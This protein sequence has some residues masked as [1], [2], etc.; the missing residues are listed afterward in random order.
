MTRTCSI[1]SARWQIK[2]TKRFVK[3]FLSMTD[4]HTNTIS[5]NFKQLVWSLVVLQK[6]YTLSLLVS[7]VLYND[8]IEVGSQIVNSTEGE[9]IIELDDFMQRALPSARVASQKFTKYFVALV[10]FKH[11]F[12]TGVYIKE[13]W[14]LTLAQCVAVLRPNQ[15]TLVM[16]NTDCEAKTGVVR[17][18]LDI[19]TH[20]KYRDG[21]SMGKYDI[22]LLKL[23]KRFPVGETIDIIQIA[24]SMDFKRDGCSIFHCS[25]GKPSDTRTSSIPMMESS[26]KII[27]TEKCLHIYDGLK[28]GEDLLCASKGS[29]MCEC[30]MGP[31]LICDEK[32]VGIGV[33]GSQCNDAEYLFTNTAFYSGWVEGIITMDIEDMENASSIRSADLQ[34][35]S[36]LILIILVDNKV[37]AVCIME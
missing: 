20:E 26:T 9:I 7:V 34:F 5:C 22:A 23:K 29:E 2:L 35:V 18:V 19:D 32:V 25:R 12:C 24:T 1:I 36:I 6:F 33:N 11:R 4:I 27:P 16:G 17:D 21:N 15:I 30:E 3:H 10:A 14:V 28:E 31:M 13:Y 8:C 37:Y